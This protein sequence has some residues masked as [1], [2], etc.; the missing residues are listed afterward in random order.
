M[1]NGLTFFQEVGMRLANNN[2]F[3]LFFAEQR[4]FITGHTPPSSYQ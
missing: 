3:P 1:E 4:S 2:E